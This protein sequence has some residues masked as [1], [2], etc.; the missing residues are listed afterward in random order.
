MLGALIAL[1]ALA[2]TTMNAEWKPAEGPLMSRWADQVDPNHVL[3]EYPRPQMRRSEWMNLNGLWE[4][5]ITPKAVQ[6]LQEYEGH[7]LV[8]FA[9]ESAL[10]GVGRWVQP[11]ERLWYR[12][13]FTVEPGWS[14]QRILLHFGA[15]DWESQVLIDGKVVGSHRG[16]YNPFSFDVTDFVTPG[17]RHELVVKVTDPTSTGRQPR[18]KQVLRPGGIW[19]TPVTGIWQTV[20]MEPVPSGGI[21]RLHIVP[22]AATGQVE[23]TAIGAR[24]PVWARAF[25]G[26][27]LVAEA[28]SRD[29]GPMTLTIRNPK[30]WSPESAFLYRLRVGAGEDVVDSYF[31]L[32]TIALGKDQ[33]GRTVLTLNGEPL[34]QFGFLDQGYWPCGLYTAPTDEALKWDIEF[35]RQLGFNLIRKHVK[36]EPARWYYWADKMGMLV[37][38]DMPSGFMDGEGPIQ[39]DQAHRDQFDYEMRS[40]MDAL[41]PFPSVVLWVIFNEGWGQ[42][43]TERI[44]DWV[45]RHDPSRLATGASGWVDY[46]TGHVNDWHIYPG[47]D[48]PMWE[49]NRASVLGEFGGLGLTIPGHIWQAQDNWGYR[50]KHTQEEFHVGIE[51]LFRELIRVRKETGMSAAVYTQTTDVETEVNGLVT[52]DRKVVKVDIERMRRAILEVYKPVR[53]VRFETVVADARTQPFTWRYTTEDPGEGWQNPN[54]DDSSWRTGESGF[55]RPNT[56]GSAVRTE[57]TTP[58]IWLRREFTI[59]E[60]VDWDEPGLAI[61][62]DE[63]VE[64]WINGRL[65][66]QRPGF[67]VSYRFFPLEA[68]PS[69]RIMVA[70]RCRQR[71][72]GQYIDVGVVN[73]RSP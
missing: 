64:V 35:T 33:D 40:M 37:W 21:E 45:V 34:F 8:P 6:T 3:P 22:D 11:D 26:N 31:G 28:E 59:P 42:F 38:Q 72:G 13:H 24:G 39:V 73:R 70:V 55:G 61:H 71:E 18:G 47:P 5:A 58:N 53:A 7:I 48:A 68:P 4:Y 14:G 63:D 44:T 52:Y 30:L 65:A 51:E 20:W 43:D 16:G 66:V 9:V 57:W 46:G 60:G 62:H 49:P 41:Q 1:A 69:G 29:G 67:T 15:V 12:R 10:S 36:V 32:R 19:Y 2:P 17:R 27:T 25:D 50:Y 56:P 23:V 54:F